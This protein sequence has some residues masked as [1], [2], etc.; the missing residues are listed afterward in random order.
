MGKY[1]TYYVETPEGPLPD[2]IEEISGA[3]VEPLECLFTNFSQFVSCHRFH[4]EEW[5]CRIIS[6]EVCYLQKPLF[7]NTF[8]ERSPGIRCCNIVAYVPR[9]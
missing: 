3:K 2:V 7:F 8:V 9:V 5:R 6:V 1:C 4:V